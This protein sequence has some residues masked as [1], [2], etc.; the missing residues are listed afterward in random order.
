VN[1]LE[2]SRLRTVLVEGTDLLDGEVGETRSVGELAKGVE[3][4]V[5]VRRKKISLE[6]GEEGGKRRRTE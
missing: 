1:R 6:K 2:D 5:A 3:T 4:V